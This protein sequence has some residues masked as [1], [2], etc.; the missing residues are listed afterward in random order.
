MFTTSNQAEIRQMTQLVGVVAF[1]YQ[2]HTTHAACKAAVKELSSPKVDQLDKWCCVMRSATTS[3]NKVRVLCLSYDACQAAV[4]ELSFHK[5][6]HLDKL[7]DFFYST[8]NLYF[9]WC[10]LYFMSYIVSEKNSAVFDLVV[11]NAI[12]ML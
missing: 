8:F 9:G 7:I 11:M 1:R 3:T 6:D 5:V 2:H 10:C 4:K 12:F